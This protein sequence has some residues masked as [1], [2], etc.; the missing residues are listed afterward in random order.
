MP[1]IAKTKPPYIQIAEHIQAQILRGELNPGDAL[2]PL[3]AIAGD[4][5]VTQTTAS[6]AV[7]WLEEQGHVTVGGPGLRTIVKDP[8]NVNRNGR[9]RARSVRRTG[10]IY[11]QGEY[12]K[13]ESAAVVLAPADVAAALGLTGSE[14]TAI[15]RERV[16][17]GPDDKPVSASVSWY[18]S[19]LATSCP[20]LLDAERI[21]QGSWGYVEEQTSRKAVRGRDIITTRLATEED[22]ARLGIDL[23]AAVKVSTTFLWTE[24]GLV[25]EYGVSLAEAG[26]ESTY[27]YTLGDSD[28]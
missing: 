4:W 19:A 1:K 18:D 11:T 5:E 26:R 8:K 23:P 2:P 17:Y 21:Q 20:R 3:R 16:T 7:A 25:V 22:A 15:R 24:D 13:I 10:R 6:R 14:P 12:A 28:S 27:D 9:D